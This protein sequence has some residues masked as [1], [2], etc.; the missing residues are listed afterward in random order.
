MGS[1]PPPLVLL[2]M[3]AHLEMGILSSLLAH[4]AKGAIQAV[5]QLLEKV[6]HKL[7]VGLTLVFGVSRMQEV[8]NWNCVFFF[9]LSYSDW[10]KAWTM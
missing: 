2:I 6:S 7:T 9:F 5:S 1:P 4:E 10:Q 8:K 3:V